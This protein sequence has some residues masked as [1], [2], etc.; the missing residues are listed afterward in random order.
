L[1]DGFED[2]VKVVTVAPELDGAPALIRALSD[3]GIAVAMGHS[4]ATFTEAEAGWKA[5]A[6]GITHL[7]NAMRGFHHREPAI[8]GFGLL[9]RDIYVEVIAD[10]H[11]LHPRTLD[12]IFTL[13]DPGKILIISDSVAE[14][15]TMREDLPVTD[16]RG[17]LLGGSMTIAESAERL[18][19]RGLDRERVTRCVTENPCRYLGGHTSA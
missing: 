4:E 3:R 8:A 11:H 6:K 18:I 19:A 17:E 15:K 7:F 1:L 5:G 2:I 13:K 14:T 10:P 9:N 16:N 12:L